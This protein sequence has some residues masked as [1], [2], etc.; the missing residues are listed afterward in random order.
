MVFR[1]VLRDWFLRA[2]SGDRPLPSKSYYKSSY[3]TNCYTDWEAWGN[4]L[5]GA[6][7]SFR[8][9]LIFALEWKKR[10]F[11]RGELEF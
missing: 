7:K 1:L 11:P 9:I 2:A 6:K 5:F 8:K 10:R 4:L 3:V